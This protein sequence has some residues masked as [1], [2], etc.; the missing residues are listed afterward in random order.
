ME[1]KRL[2]IKSFRDL[3]AKIVLLDVIPKLPSEEKY[4]LAD[5]MRRASKA[6]P[7]ILA[8]GYAKK[9]LIKSWKKYLHDVMGE[10]NEMIAHLTIT[11]EAYGNRY[12]SKELEAVI[13][14]YDQ[15]TKMLYTLAK[16]WK[17]YS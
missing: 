12:R 14:L 16:N 6:A 4:D 11:T 9:H 7:A 2:P 5:Q 1:E 15:A 13:D 8:E 10:C 17:V 3:A